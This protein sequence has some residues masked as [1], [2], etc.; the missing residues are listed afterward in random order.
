MI[1]DTKSNPFKTGDR[2]RV[3]PCNSWAY[4]F[5]DGDI[6]TVRA[7]EGN[8]GVHLTDD[9]NPNMWAS[10]G[11]F[12]KIKDAVYNEDHISDGLWYLKT[13]YYPYFTVV[14]VISEQLNPKT[15]GE[16]LVFAIDEEGSS[17][18]ADY[19]IDRFIGRV[20]APSV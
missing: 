19:G 8:Y 3:T 16:K 5:K 17:S 12:E 1:K 2:L 7:L 14:S 11:R 6:V 15:L 10:V 9:F 20:P 13:D 4:R 18:I